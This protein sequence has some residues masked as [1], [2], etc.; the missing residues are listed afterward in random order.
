MAI[1]DYCDDQ[2]TYAL[3]VFDF[4]S[5]AKDICKF[6]KTVQPSGGG[7]EPEAYELALRKA[8]KL[9]WSPDSAKAVVIIG[10]AP[11]EL[12]FSLFFSHISHLTF[13]IQHTHHHTQ[14]KPSGGNMKQMHLQ[15]LE[16]SAMAFM[17]WIVNQMESSIVRLQGEQG[18]CMSSSPTSN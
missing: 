12:F 13:R 6:V 8:R 3:K 17:H 10:D 14:P 11:R 9:S 4:S 7:D 2:S 18:P 1:G 16:S 15:S 5:N